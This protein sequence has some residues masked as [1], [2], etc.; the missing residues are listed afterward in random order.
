MVG[1]A[2]V[3]EDKLIKTSPLKRARARLPW[4]LV[5][6]AGEIISGSVI[7]FHSGI[8]EMVVA[9]AF[10]IPVIMAM[11]GNVGTQS[12]TVTVRGIA[13]GQLKIGEYCK[14]LW[15]E[16]KVGLFV[17]TI[18]GLMIFVIAYFWQGDYLLAITIG[19][20]LCLTVILATTIGTLLPLIF[21]RINIDPAVASGPFITT[22]V[23]VGSL[24]VYFALG[25]LLFRYFG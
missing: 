20:S 22:I 15:A 3:Y 11:A 17:G 14:N 10:F 24:M 5:C 7:E 1:S 2:E 9:L 18:I 12:S 6:M 25:T 19:F 8:L 23:D 21:D 4:L 16:I 13:T